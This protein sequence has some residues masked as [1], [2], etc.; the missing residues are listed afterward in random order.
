MVEEARSI[1]MGH[2][3]RKYLCTTTT[4]VLYIPHVTV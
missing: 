2:V 1:Y 4:L 3:E